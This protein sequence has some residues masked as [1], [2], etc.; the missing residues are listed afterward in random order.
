[1][2]RRD[3]LK[4]G[5]IAGAGAFLGEGADLSAREQQDTRPDDTAASQPGTIISTWNH[6][7]AANAV[8][9][10]IL[11]V[12]GR[13]LDAVERGVMVSEADPNVTSV[14][15]GGL[16]NADG[17]MELDAAIMDG[18]KLEAGAVAGLRG[19]LHPIAVARKV[20]TETPHVLLVGEGA[21]RFALRQGF[22]ETELLT[23]D[24]AKAWREW[25]Q[26]SEKKPLSPK[27]DH[28]TIGMIA[29]DRS[30]SMAASC[31]TSGAAWK[32]PGRVGDSPLI[33]HGLYCDSQVGGAAAT[34]LGEEVIKVCGS[35][36]VVEFMRQGATPEEA[37]RR[38]LERVIARTPESRSRFVGFVAL[39]RDGE[40]GFMST[41]RGFQAAVFR[42]GKH[43]LLDA[44]CFVSEER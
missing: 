9:A 38:V 42:S 8:A 20:M 37:I 14:G 40:V 24:A 34:G 30:G 1:M 15:R 44:A 32:L 6:G 11:L 19:F 39:R 18:D 41:T 27:D 12:G 23:P 10:Q 7:L 17:I 25:Q 35:Y 13:A 22:E 36:Q 4:W 5:A 31:T 29:L 21:R 2:E 16:P 33:G 3:F 26:S 28:D 43:E